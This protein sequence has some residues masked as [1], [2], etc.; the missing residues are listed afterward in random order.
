MADFAD[1]YETLLLRRERARLH[2]LPREESVGPVQI[3]VRLRMQAVAVED[4]EPRVDA[5]LAQRLYVRPGNAGGVDGAVGD[6]HVAPSQA[7]HSTW[8]K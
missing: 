8:S 4:D 6:A 1:K 7:S 2:E 3:E 5:A